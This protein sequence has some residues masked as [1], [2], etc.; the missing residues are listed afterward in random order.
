MPISNFMDLL[1]SPQ[2]F[3]YSIL[4]EVVP[5]AVGFLVFWLVRTRFLSRSKSTKL[6]FSRA[7]AKLASEKLAEETEPAPQECATEEECQEATTA[8]QPP[9]ATERAPGQ[10]G[11]QSFFA[12]R[13]AERGLHARDFRPAPQASQRAQGRA[14]N[15]KAVSS[16][17]AVAKQAPPSIRERRPN[18]ERKAATSAYSR[19]SESPGTE[20]T[21]PLGDELGCT[22]LNGDEAGLIQL[23]LEVM[24]PR[25]EETPSGTTGTATPHRGAAVPGR[26]APPPRRNPS[27][28][29]P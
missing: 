28:A 23:W 22:G 10:P 20:T 16:E 26:R 9:S 15:E 7:S 29:G 4:S 24:G 13:R 12:Q 14:T 2:T 5:V 18:A 11:P 8:G 27:R 3:T 21:D 6:A 17:K 25:K 19:P 1:P